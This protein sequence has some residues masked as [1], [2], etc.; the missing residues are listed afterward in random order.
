MIDVVLKAW[1]MVS[2]RSLVRGEI[3][4]LF[5]LVCSFCF[6][7]GHFFMLIICSI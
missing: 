5:Y 6:L 2:S 3:A 4:I 1:F 7:F